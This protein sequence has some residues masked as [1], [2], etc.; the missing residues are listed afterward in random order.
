[1]EKSP[2]EKVASK[3]LLPQDIFSENVF[4]DDG[5]KTLK[6]EDVDSVL[7]WIESSKYAR[8]TKRI[9]TKAVKEEKLTDREKQL[10]AYNVFEGKTIAKILSGSVT[11][12]EG[13]KKADNYIQNMT[14]IEDSRIVEMIRQMIIQVIVTQNSESDL[15]RRY[16]EFSGKIR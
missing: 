15:A 7:A 5:F 16:I 6:E 3:R 13:I 12:N 8:E 2:Y 10:L 4:K 14:D 1:M 11:E 9:M